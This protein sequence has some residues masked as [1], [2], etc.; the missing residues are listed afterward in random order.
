MVTA[1]SGQDFEATLEGVETGLTGTVA[2]TVDNDDGTAAVDRSTDDIIELSSGTD[3]G[4]GVY[5]ATRTAPTVTEQTEY[6]LIWD[7]GDPDDP[8]G[9]FTETLLVRAAEAFIALPSTDDVAALDR[10]RTRDNEGVEL[11]QFT[12]ETRP[13]NE[14]V[15]TLISLVAGDVAMRVGDQ[16]TMSLEAIPS[17]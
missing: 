3:P 15:E 16:T 6:T 10:A 1:R 13:T 14:Q 11:G 5:V 12:E 4:A 8:G 17:S 7:V 2:L 9:T